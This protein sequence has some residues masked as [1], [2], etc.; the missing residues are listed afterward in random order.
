[1]GGDSGPG[2]LHGLHL[3]HHHVLAL[4]AGGGEREGRCGDHH[5]GHP[6]GHDP[7]PHSRGPHCPALPLRPHPLRAGR[8]GRVHAGGVPP[9]AGDLLREEEEETEEQCGRGL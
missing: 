8:D 2:R 7:P 3:P 5:G 9:S 6:G 1:M 4:G